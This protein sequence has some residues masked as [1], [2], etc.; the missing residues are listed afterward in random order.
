MSK[1]RL[2]K[3]SK[4]PCS[5]WSEFKY[6]YLYFGHHLTG[7]FTGF[8]N[9]HIINYEILG[10]SINKIS[11]LIMRKIRPYKT[12]G[13]IRLR[14]DNLIDDIFESQMKD[15]WKF[16]PACNQ[17]FKIVDNGK[18]V[19]ITISNINQVRK[20]PIRNKY[21]TFELDNNNVRR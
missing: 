3:V 11:D 7:Y 2:L 17:S 21:G 13:D 15:W 9:D 10:I 18:K 6:K 14:K 5:N 19:I 12:F 4:Y 8:A 1:S 20:Y 16:F